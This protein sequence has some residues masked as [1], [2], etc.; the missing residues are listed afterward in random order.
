M[1]IGDLNMDGLNEIY[2]NLVNNSYSA[3]I[4]YKFNKNNRLWE[5]IILDEEIDGS[6][7][8]ME[9]GAGG[10]ILHNIKMI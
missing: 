1:T 10:A 7:K 9:I 2:A 3:V 5:K 4:Q 8:N 6:F